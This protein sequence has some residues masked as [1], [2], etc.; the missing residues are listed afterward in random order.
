[1]VAGNRN[2]VE[3]RHL[4]RG[5]LEDRGDD[6]HRGLRRVDVRVTNHE[7][8]EDVVLDRTAQL[9]SRNALLFS[10]DNVEGQNRQHSA[11]HGHRHRDA[12]QVN[13]LKELTHVVN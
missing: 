2:G 13:A 1:M 4:C 10:G 3:L 12:T 5:V 8:L 9:L 11:V 7:L 6:S